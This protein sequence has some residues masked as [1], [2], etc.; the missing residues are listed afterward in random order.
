MY[1]GKFDAKRK[2]ASVDAQELVAQRNAA[3][4][5]KEAP[6]K[7]SADEE[8]L[9]RKK[10]AAQ[11]EAP[12]AEEAP[13]KK[14]APAAEAPAK[15]SAPKKDVPAA[16]EA[17]VKKKSKKEAPAVEETPKRRGPRV[18][19]VIF[20]T[21]YFMFIL[22]FFVAVFFALQ[23]V[24]DWLVDYEA[25]QPTTKCTQVFEQLFTDPDWDALYDAAAIEDTP[26]EGKEAF[27]A[28][29]E[30]K[31]GNTKL[32]YMETSAGLSGD[33]KY[34]VKLGEEK[35]ASF[36][37][38]DKAKS[39]SALAEITDLPQWELGSIEL[40]YERTESYRIQK[41]DDHTVYVNDVALDDSYTIQK[42]TTAAEKYLPDGITGVW[43]CTQEITGL[44]STPTV[45]IFDDKGQQ[46]EVTY[47]EATRT[48]TE[49]T[50][51]NT[52]SE[53]EETVALNA[54]KA[55]ALYMI[56]KAS[57]AQ[58][59]K[60]FDTSSD[61][62]SIIVKSD[63]WTVQDNNGYEFADET[64]SDYC[65]YADDLFSARVSMKLNV[66]RKDGTI[67]EFTVD[68]TLFFE[69]QSTGKWL[70]YEMT[71]VD[72]Q[73]P[74]GQVRLTFMNGDTVLSSDF[75]NT[76]I[77]QLTTPVVSVPEGKVFTGWV[78]EDVAEDGTTTLTVVFSPDETGYVPI[79]S[80]TT[81]EP[82]TLY[83]LFEDAP[84]AATEGA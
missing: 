18:G 47:D 67:K 20:Y 79:P 50:E 83:A 41:L 35:I 14:K 61:I 44:M 74:V 13:V 62:Y 3:P 55:Y 7:A 52:I 28:Y 23:W 51:A 66:T 77:T 46:M 76:N 72:V 15:K 57:R 80:G 8:L 12:A 70:A 81:L 26:Y 38:V 33:K 65:R 1:Q 60:Y 6:V 82:M 39:D 5:K 49:R 78:R 37:L 75:Y 30:D 4:K 53:D 56:E 63:V 71:N 48:F 84:T 17:P 27:V 64:V 10:A 45:T 43:M 68:S 58:V 36:T 69:L 29:M 11:K 16:E 31:V 73:A 42:A 54:A 9:T 59:A 25:A 21:F 34:I 19:G 2:K 40:F 32:T 22:L 24:Q